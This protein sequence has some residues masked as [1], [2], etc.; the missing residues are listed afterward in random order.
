[1]PDDPSRRVWPAVRDA[2]LAVV[3]LAPVV[4]ALNGWG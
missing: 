3:L 1:M 4:V 2:L